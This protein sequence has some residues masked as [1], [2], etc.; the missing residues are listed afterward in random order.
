MGYLYLCKALLTAFILFM[1]Y[2]YL[3]IY[4]P[5]PMCQGVKDTV[6]CKEVMMAVSVEILGLYG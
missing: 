1:N 3:D 6:F 2:L 5:G 4:S